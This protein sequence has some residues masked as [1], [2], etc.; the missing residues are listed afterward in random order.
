MRKLA[1]LSLLQRGRIQKYE[2]YIENSMMEKE[3]QQV[4][5]Q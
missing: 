2:H 1:N 4:K 3:A 5:H